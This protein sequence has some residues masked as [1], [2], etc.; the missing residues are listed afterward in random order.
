M[1]SF[2]HQ[3][4]SGEDFKTA[5]E[6]LGPVRI[7]RPDLVI[8]PDGN[9]YLYRWHIVRLQAASVYFHIQVASD[10]QRPLHDHPWDNTSVIL[11]GGYDEIW[12]PQPWMRDTREPVMRKLRAGD[13]VHRLACESHRLILPDGF[14]YTMTLFSTGPRE[15]DWGFWYPEGLK[16]HTKVTKTVNGVSKHIGEAT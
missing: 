1:Q 11:S 6:I 5:L 16:L 8:A 13:V 10:P 15:R 4:L 3:I 12:E 7:A 9:P 2:P 14:G